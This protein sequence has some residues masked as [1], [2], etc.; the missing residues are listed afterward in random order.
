MVLYHTLNLDTLSTRVRRRKQQKSGN[1]T[2]EV[3][4]KDEK[5]NKAQQKQTKTPPP[6]IKKIQT[7]V[8]PQQWLSKDHAE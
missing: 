6:T 1:A 8:N 5:E 3:Q 7:N 4:V 2:D